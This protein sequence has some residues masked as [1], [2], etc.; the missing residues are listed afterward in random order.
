MIDVQMAEDAEDIR[1]EVACL[2]LL[3]NHPTIVTLKNSFE[4]EEVC[5]M[6]EYRAVL[7]CIVLYCMVPGMVPYCTVLCLPEGTT[8]L[9]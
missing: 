4:D 9:L 7:Y 1:R 3:R 5:R 6:R 8:P 2:S